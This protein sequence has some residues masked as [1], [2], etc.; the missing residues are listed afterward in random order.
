MLDHVYKTSWVSELGDTYINVY[1]LANQEYIVTL[2]DIYY[3]YIDYDRHELIT[4]YPVLTNQKQ[5]NSYSGRYT[6]SQTTL[7]I[8][9]L[10]NPRPEQIFRVIDLAK[11]NQKF[12]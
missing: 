11:P 8:K 2:K 3:G 5:P 1:K 9:C 4:T 10:D 6:V 12:D 7:V